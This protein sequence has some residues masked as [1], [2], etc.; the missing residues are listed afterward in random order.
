MDINK[1]AFGKTDWTATGTATAATVTTTKTGIAVLSPKP[2]Q[3]HI[4]VAFSLSVDRIT[5]TAGLLTIKD[6]STA[7]YTF[8]IP[9]GFYGP[10]YVELNR[11]YACAQGADA[12]G[13][14]TTLGTGVVCVVE[15]YGQTVSD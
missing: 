6:G 11:P 15:L 5:T 12:V 14:V 9:V 2:A 13:T 10:L 3:R 7:K 8:W 1:I 4:L